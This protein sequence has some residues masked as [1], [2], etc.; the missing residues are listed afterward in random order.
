MQTN[1]KTLVIHCSPRIARSITVWFETRLFNGKPKASAADIGKRSRLRLAVKQRDRTFV[2]RAVLTALLIALL[3]IEV[4]SPVA[5]QD[6]DK[7]PR[8]QIGESLGKPVYRDEIRTGKNVT[9]SGELHRLF[10][11][12]AGEEYRSQHEGEITP[13]PTEISAAMKFYDAKHAERMK[14]QEPGLLDKLKEIDSQLKQAGLNDDERGK[15]LNVKQLLERQRLPPGESFAV[16]VMKNWKIQQ[17]LYKKYGGGR[18]LF[19]QAGV[20][21]FDAT[22]KWLESLE[23]AGKF[24]ITDPKLRASLYEYWARDQG[25]W[26]IKEEKDIQEFVEPMFLRNLPKNE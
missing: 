19:Q 12:A 10:T 7:Q 21:A 14:E 2:H 11:V 6:V 26:I 25:P 18:L 15:L 24:K 23:A 3:F 1:S 20:E 4:A 16:F 17:H 13:T 22:R 9:L 8:E 5:G